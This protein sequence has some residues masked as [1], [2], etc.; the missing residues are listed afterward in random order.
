MNLLKDLGK[1]IEKP[2]VVVKKKIIIFSSDVRK[3]R[4]Q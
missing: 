4:H 3:K 2:D 1:V